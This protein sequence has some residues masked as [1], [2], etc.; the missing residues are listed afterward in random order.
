[1]QEVQHDEMRNAEMLDNWERLQGMQGTPTLRQQ[2]AQALRA[3]LAGQPYHPNVLER[4]LATRPGA[5][6]RIG[7]GV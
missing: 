7:R 3:Q 5:A 4:W 1:M 6:A 2:R